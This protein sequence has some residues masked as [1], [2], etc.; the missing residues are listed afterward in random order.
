MRMNKQQNVILQITR[1]S[2]DRNSF[3]SS[4]L[5]RRNGWITAIVYEDIIV[6][7]SML[8]SR[9]TSFGSEGSG[10]GSVKI[11]FALIKLVKMTNMNN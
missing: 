6:S 4:I 11:V 9:L 5:G 3:I 1:K 2:A 10:A 8:D 7:K